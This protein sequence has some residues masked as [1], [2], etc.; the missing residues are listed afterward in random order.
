MTSRPVVSV[1]KHD[2]AAEIA[3]SVPMPGVFS[4]PIRNDLVHF[5]HSNLAKNRRQGHAVF[6]LAGAEHSAESWGTGR[7][8]ARIPR[9]SGS[10]SGRAGQATFGNMCRKARMYAPLKIWRK[11]H[12]KVNTT[13][14]RHAVASALAASACAP[15]VMARGHRV[16]AVPELPLVIDSLAVA[17]TAA[18]LTTLNK[19]GCAEDLSKVRASKQIRQG[20]GK[21]RNS[22]YV[23]R[24]GPLIIYGDA[25]EGV[26]KL[27]RNLPGVDACHVNRLNIL[28]LAPGGHLGRFIVYTKDAFKQLNNVFGSY[29]AESLEKRGYNLNRS[30]MNC[31]DIARIIN[32]D[33]VQAKL[34]DVKTSVRVHDKTKKNP[35][36]NRAIMN[37]LNPF[38]AQQRTILA[39][40]QADRHAARAKLIKEKRSKAGRAKKHTRTVAN[41]ARNTGLEKSYRDAQDIIDEEI[42]LGAYI[43]GETEEEE[44][45]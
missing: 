6:Y 42:R 41:Q 24:K 18:L 40:Q 38:A 14:R 17:N 30:M 31:A 4:V 13:Q 28:Q 35:L 15:L 37:R 32:S 22:R 29:K 16:D 39:K 25:S 45:E 7:A 19:F 43:P 1:Y 27:S 12:A 44:D 26:R 20:V 2:A 21:Y 11:W 9:I 8:V 36:Q 34:R 33:Q 5:V 10:G 23:M 3:D